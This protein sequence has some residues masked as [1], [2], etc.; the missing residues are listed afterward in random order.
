M[1]Y[2]NVDIGAL[3]FR[4]GS[5]LSVKR[6]LLQRPVVQCSAFG[7]KFWRRYYLLL[8][9]GQSNQN[10]LTGC[11]LQRE[12]ERTLIG[13]CKLWF[14]F[15]IPIFD[16]IIFSFLYVCFSYTLF[17]FLFFRSRPKWLCKFVD[18]L[19]VIVNICVGVYLRICVCIYVCKYLCF[20][21]F[22]K[23]SKVFVQEEKKH[24]I[25]ILESSCGNQITGRN[26]REGDTC[27]NILNMILFPSKGRH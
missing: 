5:W 26:Q 24:N 15:Q 20:W 16:L 27:G 3:D 23:Y 1:C 6:P 4:P 12:G 21:E 17:F 22:T 25:T 9:C 11:C 10:S 14:F 8:I 19:T 2:R 13:F 7:G 18:T